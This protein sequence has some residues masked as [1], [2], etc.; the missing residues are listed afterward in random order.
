[1]ELKNFFLKYYV[2]VF[3]AISLIFSLFIV[4]TSIEFSIFM[5]FFGVVIYILYSLI[6]DSFDPRK[7]NNL[8]KMPYGLLFSFFVG[9]SFAIVLFFNNIATD[10]EYMKMKGISLAF[11]LFIATL[12]SFITWHRLIKK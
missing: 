5:L 3:V 4:Q 6:M 9:F 1:M 10:L 7:G 12:A 8:L 11:H 2:L